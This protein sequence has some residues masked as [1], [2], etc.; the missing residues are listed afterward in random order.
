[1]RAAA[2]IRGAA[3]RLEPPGA[4][5]GIVFGVLILLFATLGGRALYLQWIDNEFLQGQ[6]QARYSRDIEVPAYRGRIL[7]RATSR[8]RRIAAASSTATARRW[9]SRRR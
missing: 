1:M 8:C 5:A 6:G 7:A 2:P 3:P 9:R 4:R